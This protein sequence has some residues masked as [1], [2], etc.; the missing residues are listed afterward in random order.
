MLLVCSK[1]MNRLGTTKI[2]VDSMM[3]ISVIRRIQAGRRLLGVG[4]DRVV[5]TSRQERSHDASKI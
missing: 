4:K 2:L 3:R 1:C 5:T